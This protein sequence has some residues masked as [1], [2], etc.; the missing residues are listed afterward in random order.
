M[1][2]ITLIVFY[3]AIASILTKHVFAQNQQFS[4]QQAIE[5]AVQNHSSVQNAKLDQQSARGRVG[6]VRAMGLPQVN[7]FVNITDNYKIMSQFIPANVFVQQAP[8]DLIVPVA[9]GVRHTGMA[10]ISIQQLLFDGTFF[11]GLKAAKVYTELADKSLIKTKIDVA[12]NVT[13]A[14]YGVLVTEAQLQMLKINEARLDTLFYQTKVLYQQGFAEKLDVDRLQVQVNNLKQQILHTERTYELSKMLLAFQMGLP[15]AT[16]PIVLTT[17]L[18]EI[19]L[20]IDSLNE[21]HFSVTDRIEYQQLEV[22]RKLNRMNIKRLNVGYLPTFYLT[23][24]PL[25][26]N[27]GGREYD[28]YFDK[29]HRF[30]NITLS[31]SM[32]LFDGLRKKYMVQ[33]ARMELYKIENFQKELK[34]SFALEQNQAI[35]NLQSALEQLQIQRENMELA[36]EV[37][38]VAK[39]KYEQGVGSS[40][41]II[42]AET[43]YKNAETNYFSALY[44]ALIAKTDYEKAFGKI[45]VE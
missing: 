35:R 37:M 20:N 6:E 34:R 43:S 3:T 26:Y 31:I 41:E 15:D 19:Q 9:F 2:P 7:A 29:W 32:P 14:Y 30:G 24:T 13:K 36:R 22:Q 10:G 27:V 11:L 28:I 18:D 38:R 23:G 8:P 4:L 45:K 21:G 16:E 39:A 17:K 40:L 1:K 12:A 44:N 5:Y 42:E 33:Q 25:G